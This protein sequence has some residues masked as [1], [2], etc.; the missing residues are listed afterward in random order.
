[1]ERI[2]QDKVLSPQGGEQGQIDR[3][4]GRLSIPLAGEQNHRLAFNS[5]ECGDVPYL[6]LAMSA[7]GYVAVEIT[8]PGRDGI[9]QSP[10]L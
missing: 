2:K 1:M 6:H 5:I 8:N 9:R 10:H 3:T 7:G 4:A